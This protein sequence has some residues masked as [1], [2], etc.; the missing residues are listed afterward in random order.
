MSES[1]CWFL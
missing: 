1:D